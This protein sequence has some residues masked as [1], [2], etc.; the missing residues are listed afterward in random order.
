MDELG[1]AAS[2]AKSVREGRAP[3]EE[4][5]K[6]RL[7][8]ATSRFERWRPGEEW[9]A[10]SRSGARGVSRRLVTMGAATAV[11]A[12]ML[13]GA[14]ALAQGSGLGTADKPVEIR[15]SANE[16]FSNQLQTV[17]VPEFNK[18]F[19][20][21]KVKVDGIPYV[22]YLAKAML[23][24]T[25][26]SPVYDVVIADEP[27]VP[28]LAQT[29]GFL[30][31]R[32][33]EVAAM[34]AADYDWDDFYKGA[35]A[36]GAW[37]EGQY[38]VPLRSN[39]LLL[40]YNR[41]LYRKAGV[42]E[43]TPEMTWPQFLER[44]PKLVQDTDGD[45]KADAWGIDTYFMR[46]PLTPT[47]WQS[48][49]NS[50]GG[51]LFDDSLKPA[52]NN[53]AGVKALETHKELL[54]YAPAGALGHG[55]SESLQAFR[56]GQVANLFNWG[57]VFKATAVDKATTKLTFSEVGIQVLPVGS[58]SAGTH[59][60]IWNGLVSA[61]SEKKQA[62]WAFLQWL[63][64]KEGEIWYANELGIFP[65]RRSTL[66]STPKE[67]W[68][69]PVFAALRQGFDAVDKGQMWRLRHPRSDAAQQVLADETARALA[70]QVS[71]EEALKTASDKVARII[72]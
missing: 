66:A 56:Q 33:K 17:V 5:S 29:S 3:F 54:K 60:G 67:E 6:V 2:H 10:Q 43:P 37:K 8:A 30:D 23:D 69:V 58:N 22:E 55:F 25:S 32:G 28:Q 38:G 68:L 65:A 15:V 39:L 41:S 52:F 11:A 21:I 46:E 20:H 47:I 24:I 42:P 72:K 57:S 36:S 9:M 16:A 49:L 71:T 48:I 53:E 44:L 40:F 7:V 26:P 64:S 50:N 1:S 59:R 45:G 34:T 51:R 4:E 61:K 14:G 63:S 35:L 62:G 31:L 18:R 70:G 27:W 13:G 19:P 12:A